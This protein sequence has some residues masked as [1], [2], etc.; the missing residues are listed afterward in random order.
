MG[1]WVREGIQRLSVVRVLTRLLEAAA[2]LDR[3]A[4]PRLLA[5]LSRLDG[6]VTRWLLRVVALT[7]SVLVDV[8]VPLLATVHRAAEQHVLPPSARCTDAEVVRRSRPAHAARVRGPRNT[9]ELALAGAIVFLLGVGAAAA[10]TPPPQQAV[11]AA[12]V[13]AE[14]PDRPRA[15]MPRQR[16]HAVPA[17]PEARPAPPEAPAIADAPPAPAAPPVAEAAPPAPAPAPQRWLPS[18]TGMWLHEWHRTEGGNSAA[19]VARAQAAGVS[20]LYVQTGST[21][22]AFIGTE[23]LDELLPATSGTDIKVIAWDFPKLV[24]PEGDA[25]RMAHAALWHVPGAPRVAAVAPD[26]ETASEG[27]RLSPDAVVRYYTALRAALPPDIAI[28][29]TIPWPSEKRTGFYPYAETAAHSDALIPMAYW[30]NRAPDVVTATSMQFLAQ[31]GLPVMPVGQGYDG[32][33]D[34]PYLPEDADPAGSV[35]R[36]V[37]AARA[38]GARSISLWSWQTMYPQAWDVLTRA[39][40]GPWPPPMP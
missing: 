30:Y 29:A 37:D 40:A 25:R 8:V 38:G 24:D 6:V 34:A 14:S 16:T 11:T 33:L 23:A 10:G 39:S 32:R 27:T 22:K 12:S 18:G 26:I 4:V 2:R 31:F 9:R 17:A 35:Q 3:T 5:P 15:G 20:H 36:F 13:T 7:Q 19:V 28:L 21:G 1:L